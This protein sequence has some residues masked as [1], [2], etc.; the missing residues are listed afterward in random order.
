MRASTSRRRACCDL[1]PPHRVHKMSPL[2]HMGVPV[3]AGATSG[4]T[5]L[6]EERVVGELR[7][8]GRGEA[9]RLCPSGDAGSGRFGPRLHICLHWCS[10]CAREPC[11][12]VCGACVWC[13]VRERFLVCRYFVCVVCVFKYSRI[14]RQSAPPCRVSRF[15]S[16]GEN[17][18]LAGC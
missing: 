6:A 16:S 9:W 8:R 14:W 11:V 15:R 3:A 4:A 2:P 13:V 18:T 7:G 12:E 5:P 1:E 10:F 17:Q